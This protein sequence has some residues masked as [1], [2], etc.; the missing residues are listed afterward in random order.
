MVRVLTWDNLVAFFNSNFTAA[1]AGAFAG[2]MA[3]QRIADRTR[4]REFVLTEV[5]NTNAAIMIAYTVCNAGL[6][7][8]KQLVK[9]I[10]DSFVATR[11]EHGDF[12]ARRARGDLVDVFELHLDLRTVQ[13][14]LFPIDVL[15]TQMFEKVSAVG[16]PLALTAALAGS[17]ETLGNVIR[18][19]SELIDR[20][21]GLGEG[22]PH[23][24]PMYLGEPYGPGHVSEEFPDT[25]DAMYRLTDDV[26]FFSS[27]LAADLMTHGKDVLERY[28]K[29]VK[30]KGQRISSADFSDAREKGLMPEPANY[31]D[32]TTGFQDAAQQSAP[33]D[34]PQQAVAGP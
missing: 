8:K 22:H 19:R 21:R 24:I 1:L 12:K 27:L 7:L 18:K 28:G 23:L 30:V 11:R 13:M 25:V 17:V 26:I 29:A 20:F 6:A 9:D 16:R 10:H 15:R 5:R 3:A 4:Q 2:A 14:P 33:G 31:I 32:W 34:R